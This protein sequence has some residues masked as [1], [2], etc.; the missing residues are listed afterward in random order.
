MSQLPQITIEQPVASTNRERTRI[1]QE[2]A[3]LGWF[4]LAT[5]SLVILL[6][7]LPGYGARI[8][9]GLP[10]HGPLVEPSTGYI[11]L[12]AV[13]SI[14]S[15]V[16]AILSLSLSAL[17][18]RHRF[19]N[20]AVAVVS[21]YLLLY[22][23]IMT[24]PLENW[25]LY[26]LG[27]MDFAITVQTLLMATPTLALLLLFPNGKFIPSWTR[28]VLV[29]S[30]PWNGLAL[31]APV[32]PYRTDDLAGLIV[33]AFFWIAMLCL[34][35]YAQIYRYRHVSTRDERQ[36][37]KWVLLGFAL[38]IGY[39]LISTYP[40]FYVTSL[41]EDTTM[42]WWSPLTELTWWL[43]LTI[44]PVTLT[45]AI[46]R[47]RLWNINIVIN[48]AL[49]YGALTFATMALYVLVVGALGSLLNVGNSTF[50][51][52][53]TTGLVAVLF[54]PLRERLQRGVNRLMYGER[55]DPV[56]V[57]RQLG[58]QLENTGSPRDALISITETVSRTLKLPYVAFELGQAGEVVAA[59]GLSRGNNL[60]LPL[61]YQ[62]K[63]TGHLVVAPRS[64]GES[65]ST[66]DLQLLENIT[67]QAGAAAHAAKMDVDLRLSRQRLVTARE[68]E[69]RRLRRDL[70]DGLGPNLASMTLKLEAAHNL[71]RKDSAKAEQL[72][73]EL[74]KQTQGTIQDIRTLVYE[75]RPP[76]L[77]EL[78]LV[79]AIQ[80]FIEK[81]DSARPQIDLDLPEPLPPLP[82][83]FEVA[84]YRIVLEGLTNV[85]RHADAQQARAHIS[86][87]NDRLVVEI[88][89]DGNGLPE[90]MVAGV[91]LA[92][93]R[94]R[95]E[96]LGGEFE[97][98]PGRP[99]FHMR[100]SLP[101][102][103]E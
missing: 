63:P 24:G 54:Q 7:S 88:D 98:L 21:I 57:L 95:A 92:S 102:Q 96:E 42:P 66:S 5:L 13:N 4:S 74:I 73:N 37:S 67:H 1:W 65:F 26:W 78:G 60:R 103:K 100:A 85:L 49:V 12:Q 97:V 86:V 43:S 36:Q 32:F 70:H 8:S 87:Q 28:W 72:I 75:L 23:I 69:R 68:E 64:P 61:T 35:I 16:S 19:E 47:S 91:G 48:R 15:L 11:Y 59:Y 18:F 55:D 41:P 90:D 33:L 29:A 6:S 71:L 46:T 34:G 3:R 27:T 30:L 44:V 83:A 40:Y 77:D 56:A 39:L 62:S 10:G 58:A 84:V 45:I 53:L 99:G 20:P 89:D 80:G 31:L 17:L 93:M 51:A 9:S 22:G 82:A 79:G 76:A 38:W 81:Q 14:A 52:F 94:E 50:I 101:L 2:A 25:G